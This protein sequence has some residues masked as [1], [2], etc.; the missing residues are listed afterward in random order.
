[1]RKNIIFYLN[2]D[3]LFTFP[4]ALF[5]FKKINSKYSIYL[6]LS[7]TSLR[8][9]IKIILILFLR[10]ELKNL[11]KYYNKKIS[12]EKLLSLKNVNQIKKDKYKKFEFGISINYPKKIIDLKNKIYNFHY[13]NF[14]HQRG[15]FIFFYK[16][17][18]NWSH[19]DLT[20]HQINSKLD[21]G[22]ILNN[23]SVKVKNM[24]TLE[25]IAL[26][27]KNKAFFWKSFKKINKKRK[28]IKTSIGPIN[29]EPS[30][31]DILLSKKNNKSKIK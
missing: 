19:V 13:G 15:S 31:L 24:K 11:L 22:K 2:N 7:D 27:L 29:K 25:L 4:I 18:Y 9:K 14:T 8:K 21:S 6:K 16:D 12:L 20:F 30:F 5:L 28:I 23:H 17:L 26:P 3:E 10:G 1:M